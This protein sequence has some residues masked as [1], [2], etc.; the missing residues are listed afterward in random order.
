MPM[1]VLLCLVYFGCYISFFLVLDFR[2]K[3]LISSH[4]TVLKIAF[5]ETKC[6]RARTNVMCM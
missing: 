4:Y 5:G 3:D 1:R 2:D 6:V